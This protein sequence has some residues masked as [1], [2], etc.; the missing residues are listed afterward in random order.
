MWKS[1]CEGQ[2]S[3]LPQFKFNSNSVTDFKFKSYFQLNSEWCTTLVN[4]MV[5]IQYHGIFQGNFFVRVKDHSH[6]D[7]N[8]NDNYIISIHTNDNFFYSAALNAQF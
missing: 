7:N 3:L 8:Y 5:I 2:F 6:Q 1:H 4:S